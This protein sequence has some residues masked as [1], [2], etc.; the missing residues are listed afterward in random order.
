MLSVKDSAIFLLG[1]A[2]GVAATKYAS[3]SP[4]EKE[5]LMADLKLKAGNLKD[6]ADNAAGKAR[7][8]FEEFK[9]KGGEALKD[10]FKDAQSVF[11]NIFNKQDKSTDQP[12]AGEAV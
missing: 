12:T 10:H 9:E 7:E 11:N 6:E 5:K 4:E 2:A 8:Y 1:I 3:M